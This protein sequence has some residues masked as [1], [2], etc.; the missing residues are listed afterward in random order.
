M[1]YQYSCEQLRRPVLTN[2]D[3]EDLASLLDPTRIQQR[4]D[5]RMKKLETAAQIFG[6]S[7]GLRDQI[8]SLSI[9]EVTG[10]RAVL[11]DGYSNLMTTIDIEGTAK[12]VDFSSNVRNSIA[13]RGHSQVQAAYTLNELYAPSLLCASADGVVQ[14]WRNFQV[15]DEQRLST[16]FRSVLSP[17]AA[18]WEAK[19][20]AN[21]ALSASYLLFAAGGKG[22]EAVYGW[23]LHKEVCSIQ[24]HVDNELEVDRIVASDSSSCVYAADNTG[25]ISLFDVRAGTIQ[26]QHTQPSK[27]RIAS[28]ALLADGTL[29]VG[30]PSGEMVRIDMRAPGGASIGNAVNAHKGVLTS[31][32]SHQV[33][34]I[35][36][37]S[38]R[39]V[40]KIWRAGAGDEPMEQVA[41]VRSRA[42]LLAT[43]V[44]AVSALNWHPYELMLAAGGSQ[45]GTCAVMTLS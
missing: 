26:Q 10:V 5:S 37:T 17:P 8:T 15:R 24:F 19:R 6:G 35:F 22:S 45:D 42:P 14:V 13:L 3:A 7:L 18:S 36:A 34:N 12:V 9:P 33:T 23:N 25:A 11:L 30:Y 31:I 40:V 39:E 2:E 27:S 29:V 1:V 4:L 16:T 38:A 32:A 44:G 28:M 41:V 20:P 21:Y 43:P